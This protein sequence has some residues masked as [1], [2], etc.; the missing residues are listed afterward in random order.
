MSLSA[1]NSAKDFLVMGVPRKAHVVELRESGLQPM[2]R[3]DL[4][5]R[6][7]SHLS[8]QWGFP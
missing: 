8:G 6:F 2:P 5:Q 3:S 7:Y 1:N 4:N